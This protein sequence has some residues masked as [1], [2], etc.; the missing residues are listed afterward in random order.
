MAD[1]NPT[2][3]AACLRLTV[4]SSD[5][6]T[7]VAFS[8]SVA[9]VYTLLGCRKLVASPVNSL[10]TPVPGQTDMPGTGGVLTLTD[11]N[12]PAPAFYRVTVKFP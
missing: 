8:S 9:L 5:P 10:W 1:T 11:T 2:N 12:P 6:P 3:A 7:V 4:L